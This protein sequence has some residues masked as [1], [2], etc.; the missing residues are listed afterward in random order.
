MLRALDYDKVDTMAVEFTGYARTL[1]NA[2]RIRLAAQ[3]ISLANAVQQCAV[4]DADDMWHA[5][6]T[7]SLFDN[8]EKGDTMD[9]GYHLH[10]MLESLADEF[11]AL[12]DTMCENAA[13]AEAEAEVLNARAQALAKLTDAEKELLGLTV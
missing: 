10:N 6:E 5:K 2:E 12:A 1:D 8:V 3:V 7:T 11:D 4:I 13:E 9:P